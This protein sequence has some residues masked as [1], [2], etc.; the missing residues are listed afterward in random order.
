[1]NKAREYY[2]KLAKW[3]TFTGDQS[4]CYNVMEEIQAITTMNHK[5]LEDVKELVDD[6]FLNWLWK[7]ICFHDGHSPL[8]HSDFTEKISEYFNNKLEKLKL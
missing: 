8:S 3:K 1:M 4:E 2:K 5:T 6:K 7:Y